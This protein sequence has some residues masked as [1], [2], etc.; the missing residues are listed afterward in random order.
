MGCYIN[1]KGES[2]EDWLGS[3]AVPLPSEPPECFRPLDGWM[4]VC[5]IDNYAYTAAGVAFN[6]RELAAFKSLD[7][8]PKW[9]FVAPIEAIK[10]VSPLD[11]YLRG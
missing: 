8:R 3:E 7:D 5:L 9:W 11:L 2:K 6:D 10:K 1:P 4:I